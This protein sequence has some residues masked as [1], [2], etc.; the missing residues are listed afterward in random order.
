[1]CLAPPSGTSALKEHQHSGVCV[2]DWYHRSSLLDALSLA[3]SIPLDHLQLLKMA[4]APTRQTSDTDLNQFNIWMR[5]QPWFQEWHRQR[6]L[7]PSGNSNRKLT[8]REQAELE[9][10]MRQNGVQLD[11]GMHIDSGGSLNQKNRLGRNL[12][13]G[14]GLTAAT[15]ATMGA[16]GAGP[17]AG[18]FTGATPAATAGGTG[19]TLTGMSGA[20][21]V[22]VGAPTVAGSTTAG[23]AGMFSTLANVLKNPA[24][25]TVLSG[26]GR[27]VAGA[28][29]AAA[30]NRG[31]Q[32]EAQL[33]HDQLK[34]TAEREGRARQSDAYRKAM[35]GQL[36]SSYQPSTRPAGSEGRYSQGFITPE[37]R[38]AGAL[39]YSQGMDQ[40]R[41]GSAPS[42]TPYSELPTKPGM[43]E[44]LA[45]YAGPGLSMFDLLA[46][47]RNR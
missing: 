5:S 27:M 46:E 21:I 32:I 8:D 42:I 12:A 17:M 47:A 18:L 24:T 35:L 7:N 40:L 37:A 16:A 39:L 38:E 23:G 22:A 20:P 6:G 41:Q 26:V 15:L 19:A 10:L 2:F 36:A 45:S 43:F 11:S 14:A 28:G 4:N 13:I 9:S 44:R 30:A 1:M 34:L 3:P 25:R 31:T 33:A 29:D